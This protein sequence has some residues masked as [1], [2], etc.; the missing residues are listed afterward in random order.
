MIKLYRS[1]I[2]AFSDEVEAQLKELVLAHEVLIVDR[3]EEAD[4]L[5]RIE[6]GRRTYLR[7]QVPAFMMMISREMTIQREMQG[8]SCKIDPD[9]GEGCL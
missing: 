2:C 8:D 6:E 4:V 1:K 5:P 9:T 7:D 3:L